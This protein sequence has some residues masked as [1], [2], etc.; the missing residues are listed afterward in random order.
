MTFGPVQML[1][2]EFDNAGLKGEILP[3]LERLREAGL[4]R[5]IDL[6]VV[7]KD[8]EGNVAAVEAS[9]LGLD[10][11][12]EFGAIAGALIGFGAAGEDGLEAGAVAGAELGADG[13]ILTGEGE[14]WF[15]AD[16]IPPGATAAVALIE[17]TWAIPLR[18]AITAAGGITLADRWIHPEDLLELGAAAS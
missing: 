7:V 4:V 1:I 18:D 2:L 11:A 8:D 9:D 12:M 15:V 17:H 10:E 5:L 6:L 13:S 3:E 16:A 14:E